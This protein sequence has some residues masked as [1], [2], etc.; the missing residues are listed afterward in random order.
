MQ[1]D[2]NA[3]CS[4]CEKRREKCSLAGAPGANKLLTPAASPPSHRELSPFHEAE[5]TVNLLHMEL[6]HHFTQ[7]TIHTLAFGSSWS[8]L[9]HLA[10]HVSFS[11]NPYT[12]STKA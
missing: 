6:F 4:N 2:E 5:A 7:V 3:P 10:F 8:E 11:L 1:C 12:P 9:I